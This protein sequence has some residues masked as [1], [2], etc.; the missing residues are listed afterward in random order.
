MSMEEYTYEGNL[1]PVFVF[2]FFSW[3]V[4]K[5]TGIVFC[6]PAPWCKAVLAMVYKNS[7]CKPAL[8]KDTGYLPGKRKQLRSARTSVKI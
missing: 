2:C 6:K 8:I 1:C 5:S 7:H 3:V 4:E